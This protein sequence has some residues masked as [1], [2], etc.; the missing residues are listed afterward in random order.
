MHY[1]RFDYSGFDFVVIAGK[2]YEACEELVRMI[3]VDLWALDIVNVNVV[4]DGDE[5][6]EVLIYGTFPYTKDHCAK[7]EPVLW[8]NVTRNIEVLQLV[9]LYSD[10]M[11]NFFG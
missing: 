4:I 2:V 5:P 3:L 8:S 7:V 6:D 10:R 1:E 9:D 11:R